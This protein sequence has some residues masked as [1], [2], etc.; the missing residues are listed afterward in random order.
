MPCLSASVSKVIDLDSL[1]P[2]A[3]GKPIPL[4][5]LPETKGADKWL[6]YNRYIGCLRHKAKQK[7]KGNSFHSVFLDVRKPFPTIPK[8]VSGAG[9]IY[10]LQNQNIRYPTIDELKYGASYPGMFIITGAFD[11]Q[12]E[13][14]GNSVP[15]LFIRAIARQIKHILFNGESLIPY[16]QTMSYLDIL[17]AAWLDHLKPR[18]PD[19][20]TVISTFAG[21]GG[22]SLG[23]SM[24]GYRELLAVEW[25]NNAVET[26]RLNFPDV[27][28]YHGDITKLSVEECLKLAGIEPGELDLLEG[29]PPLSR[30]LNCRQANDG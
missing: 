21:G 15:P 27:P 19:A 29:S 12:W 28:V 23:Y 1:F 20:P 2:K 14:I 22:S 11:Q 24:A 10:I 6:G 18:E 4:A 9:G 16:P 7:A 30:L 17:E 26:F 8:S 25:D 3:Q 13:R 5:V